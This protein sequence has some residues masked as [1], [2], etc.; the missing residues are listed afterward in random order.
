MFGCIV[1]DS[2]DENN[3]I[4][5]LEPGKVKNYSSEF[6]ECKCTGNVFHQRCW[7]TY[8]SS[9]QTCPLCRKSAIVPVQIVIQISPEENEPVRRMDCHPERREC[10]GCLG[11]FSA[12]WWSVAFSYLMIGLVTA[13]F[14]ELYVIACFVAFYSFVDVIMSFADCF[15]CTYGSFYVW[16]CKTRTNWN[17]FTIGIL[18]RLAVVIVTMVF[19]K[20]SGKVYGFK[21]GF[22]MSVIHFSVV[23]GCLFLAGIVQKFINTHM[24]L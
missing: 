20:E 7:K 2:T 12:I 13:E 1:R 10:I 19:L 16:A 11:F 9:F 3:C 15:R 17:I 22:V 18:V 23:M 14:D 6:S 4:L 8:R 21:V 5:C 24:C